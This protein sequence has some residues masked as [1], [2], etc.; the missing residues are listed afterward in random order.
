M[1]PRRAGHVASLSSSKCLRLFCFTFLAF[2]L[3]L[4]HTRYTRYTIYSYIYTHNS[5]P[6]NMKIKPVA[7]MSDQTETSVV[8]NPI[9]LIDHRKSILKVDEQSLLP[10]YRE[11]TIIIE[12]GCGCHYPTNEIILLS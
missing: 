11:R 6:Q 3:F 8:C 5:K 2:W 4:L 12:V 10:N 9:T 1:P 7:Q